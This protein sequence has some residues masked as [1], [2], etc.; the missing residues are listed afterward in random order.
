MK[1]SSE[2]CF[3]RVIRAILQ[4]VLM[5][6]RSVTVP[7]Q[8]G[9]YLPSVMCLV[10]KY[11]KLLF[12]KMLW[13]EMVLRSACLADVR[14]TNPVLQTSVGLLVCPKFLPE[15]GLILTILRWVGRSSLYTSTSFIAG[16]STPWLWLCNIVW[17]ST[18]K[19]C[20][21]VSC[22]AIIL[23]ANKF[24]LYISYTSLARSWPK[25]G[26]YPSTPLFQFF[27]N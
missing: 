20:K 27:V 14:L 19:G 25:N 26:S 4:D 16:I 8:D 22:L 10:W 2:L 5:Q 18:D 6:F 15:K 17:P 1:N 3:F 24:H 13:V 23:K 11:F 12:S 7:P 9:L 21:N